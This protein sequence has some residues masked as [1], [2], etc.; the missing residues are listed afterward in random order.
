MEDVD[1]AGARAD[2]V[3]TVLDGVARRG[4]CERG[5]REQVFA[6]REQRRERRGMRAAGTMR[7]AGVMAANRDLESRLAVEELVAV[8]A[9]CDDRRG[10]AEFDESPRLLVRFARPHERG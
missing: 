2:L 5:G 4:G 1:G 6:A 10:R 3:E 9:A 7:R 8:A